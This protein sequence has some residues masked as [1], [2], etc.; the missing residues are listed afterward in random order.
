MNKVCKKY[1]SDAKKFF[2]IMGKDERNFLRRLNGQLEE[3]CED[4]NITSKQELFEQY[5]QPYEVANDY[6][7]SVDTDKI[8]KKIKVSKY[9][10][11]FI[12]VLIAAILIVSSVYITFTAHQQ[13]QFDREEMIDSTVV[14]DDYKNST[15]S[16]LYDSIQ[17]DNF[18]N[19]NGEN[20]IIDE[21]EIVEDDE[22]V[23][24]DEIIE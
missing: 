4:K 16:T 22:I 20:I 17:S 12:A 2:P 23:F 6:Y 1:I 24:E 7:E 14:H 3:F 13:I 5:R 18:I 9:I 19:D 21:N 11:V 15:D 8:I 10:K